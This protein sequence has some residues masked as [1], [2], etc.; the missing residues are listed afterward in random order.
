MKEILLLILTASYGIIGIVSF[1]A[2]W[3]TIKDLYHGK[4]SANVASY[5]LWTLTG[6]IAFLYSIF[7]LP[8]FLFQIVSFLGFAA[9]AMVLILRVRLEYKK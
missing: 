4:P 9:C 7:I 8:D 3:P 1:L 2:Y 6:L 5:I